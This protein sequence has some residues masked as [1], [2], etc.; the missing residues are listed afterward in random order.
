MPRCAFSNPFGPRRS[1]AQTAGR[2]GPRRAGSTSAFRPAR[3]PCKRPRCKRLHKP[4]TSL[5]PRFVRPSVRRSGRTSTAKSAARG[6]FDCGSSNARKDRLN[7]KFHVQLEFG[8]FCGP[9]QWRSVWQPGSPIPACRGTHQTNGFSQAIL[10]SLVWRRALARA[11]SLGSPQKREGRVA[12]RRE[13]LRRTA[14]TDASLLDRKIAV[15]PGEW[16]RTKC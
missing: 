12:M 9:W 7:Q 15:I 10:L 5:A 4:W 13:P 11:H 6:R 16:K 2:A 3:C 1:R 8:G 14:V